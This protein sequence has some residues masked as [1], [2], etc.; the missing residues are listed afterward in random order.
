MAAAS[1]THR[2]VVTIPDDPSYPVGTGEWNDTHVITG[3]ENVDNTSDVNKPVST[4]QAAAIA[5]KADINSPALTGVPTAPTQAPLLNSTALATC[6]F[7]FNATRQKLASNA[8]FFVDVTLGLDTNAGLSAGAGNAW[9]TIQ[10][11][12]DYIS[13][14]IDLGGFSVTVQLADGTYPE[15]VNLTAVLGLSRLGQA[16]AIIQGNA[17]TN[18]TVIVQPVAGGAFAAVGNFSGW[19]LK[20]LKIVAPTT[21]VNADYDSCV[22]LDGVSFGACNIHVQATNVGAFIEFINNPYSVVGNCAGHAHAVNEALILWQASAT[23]SFPSGN[24]AVSAYWLNPTAGGIID[25][26]AA[27]IFSGLTATG[28]GLTFIQSFGG[29]LRTSNDSDPNAV[30][31]AG[32]GAGTISIFPVVAGPTY[33]NYI[34]ILKSA[35]SI[36]GRSTHGDANVTLAASDV[37]FTQLA[38][39]LTA[40]RT[41]QLPLSNS[42]PAGTL[43]TISDAGGIGGANTLTITRQGADSFIGV[44]VAGNSITMSVTFGTVSVR[45]D[46]S[47]GW[48]LV[49]KT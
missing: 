3:L 23:C 16:A 10:H 14:N 41:W 47:A 37:P 17:A 13:K 34:A 28:A 40:A 11:A 36:S 15:N 9:R 33:A 21:G 46:G 43:L 2:K 49:G 22:Y 44:G 5:L 31:P 26:S 24:P 27:A 8:T 38:A 30:L 32:L 6:A 19:T 29:V 12:V 48:Y 35:L 20:N 42:L 39:G 25:C 1:V 45:N 18:S 4:A 7:V